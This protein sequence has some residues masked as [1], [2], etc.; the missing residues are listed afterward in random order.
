VA[1]VRKTVAGATATVPVAAE[2][3]TT[4]AYAARDNAGNAEGEKTV[5]VRIDRT[6]PT[7]K[8]TASPGTLWP[9][10]HK[11]VPISVTV[12][13]TDGRSGAAGFILQSVTSNEPDDA[14]GAGD[15]ATTGDIQGFGVGTADTTGQL[16]A[17]RGGAR[18]GRVYT[19]TYVG[20]DAAG[21]QRTCT[22]T[23]TV[24][25]SCTGAKAARATAAVTRARRRH[26]VR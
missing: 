8:C 15:G 21:N 26:R 7:V 6:V 1:G 16:R 10:D 23:V 13:V 3:T 4:I 12:K 25:H 24:P 20:Q 9:V 2:G 18:N 22:T 5:L 11:L 17:E 19:L 14:P